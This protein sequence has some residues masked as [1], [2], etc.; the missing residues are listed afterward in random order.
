VTRWYADWE[1]HEGKSV[2]FGASVAV[3]TGPLNSASFVLI[4]KLSKCV[5]I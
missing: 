2:R 4:N 3:E 5:T 1:R